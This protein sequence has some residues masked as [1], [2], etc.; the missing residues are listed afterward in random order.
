MI[1]TRN[2]PI[3]RIQNLIGNHT[4]WYTCFGASIR[5]LTFAAFSNQ[6]I[7]SYWYPCLTNF[8][9]FT[10][11]LLIWPVYEVS[12]W[13]LGFGQFWTFTMV[14]MIW[15]IQ[16]FGFYALSWPMHKCFPS[17]T[18]FDHFM[19]FCIVALG[20]DN[21]WTFTLVKSILAFGISLDLTL[22]ANVDANLWPWSLNWHACNWIGQ[23]I[24]FHLT[25][26]THSI[27]MMQLFWPIEGVHMAMVL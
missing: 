12:L 9:T 26:F 22:A 16:G 14:Q 3:Q 19:N 8:W 1:S 23:F 2:I 6:L 11:A 10:L 7:N 4:L 21:L 13:T 25:G 15:T 18:C 20:F 5:I 17:C 27:N 24:D